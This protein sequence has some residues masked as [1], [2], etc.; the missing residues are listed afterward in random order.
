MQLPL[1]LAF[2][3]R[4]SRS[5]SARL[6]RARRRLLLLELPS[7]TFLRARDSLLICARDFGT[8]AEAAGAGAGAGAV[9]DTRAAAAA[10][11]AADDA[12]AAGSLI[13]GRQA[14][15]SERQRHAGG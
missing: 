7:F 9:A 1:Q 8:E 5:L 14:A 12:L 3:L 2:I 11:A 13:S 10:E 4:L 6:V 15:P